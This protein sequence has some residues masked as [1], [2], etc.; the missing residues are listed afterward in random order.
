MNKNVF[1]TS[2]PRI[3]WALV[4]LAGLLMP[5]AS[6]AQAPS[7][8]F[9][10]VY[11]AWSPTPEGR[12]IDS[13]LYLNLDGS[14]LLVDDLLLGE[15]PTTRTGR[16]APG[17]TGVILTLTND[18]AGP[19]PQAI[20]VNLD[21]S[22]GQPLVTLPGDTAL[23]GRGWRF[24]AFP[25]L[26]EKRNALSYNADVATAAIAANG[27]G[28]VYKAIVPGSANDWSEVTLTLF[29]DFRVILKRNALDGR[30]P[31]LT[32]GAWQNIGGQ[33]SLTLTEADG[34]AFPTPVE[35]T[36]TVE[37]GLLRGQTTA[38]GSVADLVGIPFYRLEGLA[39]SV[40]VL[41]PGEVSAPGVTAPGNE[42]G[43]IGETALPAAPA[44]AP[45]PVEISI[46]Y[47][48]VFEAA[49]C[50]QEVQVDATITCGYLTAPE[51]R[52]RA[53]SASIRL[54]VVTL[55]AQ[56]EPAADPLFV[57]AGRA[58]E[59]S[60][61]LVQWFTNA[62]VRAKRNV[63]ILHP[64]GVGLSE[65]SL[66]CSEFVAS[67]ERQVMMQSLADCYNRLLQEGRDLAGYSLDQSAIDVAD[68][69]EALALEQ[70][71]LVGNGIGATVAQLVADRYPALV[72]SIVLES[73]LPVGVNEALESPFGA[74][75]ALRKV[76]ADCSRDAAC[77]AAYPDLESRFLEMIDWYN[78]N[79]TPASIGFGDGDAIARLV[80]TKLQM[81]G[82]DVPALINALYTGDFG[83]A[84]Q[85][86]PV[87]GGC[88]LPATGV[89]AP[90]NAITATTTITDS[91]PALTA[92]V[93]M[94]E[95]GTVDAVTPSP[96]APQSW[97]DYFT[98]PDNPEGAEEVTLAR[99]QTEL[100][101]ETRAELLQFLDSLAVENFLPLLAVTGAPAQSIAS[102]EGT[103][104]S[105]ACAEDAPR[106][107]IDD[108]QR[109]SKRLPSQVAAWLT[110][111][112][113]DLLETCS[114]WSTPPAAP[115]ARVLP[116]ASAPALVMA[117]AHDPV[118]PARWAR[119]AAADFEQV[120]VRIFAG[121]GHNLLQN[122]DSCAHA[123]LAAFVARPDQAPNLF[124]L[125]HQTPA[126]V[127][128]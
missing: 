56:S 4:L 124:C 20:V 10:G 59:D 73:P 123:V 75:D 110:A 48:P 100:G 116:I 54:F 65:P 86:A 64:R 58:G 8:V 114:L 95:A 28:G 47:E 112:A 15:A 39:N 122:P 103:R 17:G 121:A 26:V 117:G 62:P 67:E 77:G 57:L 107:T 120:F 79:P 51:N 27:L 3:G 2:L 118:T 1:R 60:S 29:P 108:V 61:A 6:L 33:P 70:I 83:V 125:R 16:W 42:P 23:D 98:N 36:F 85:L 93:E 52:N 9:A 19:L 32:Y 35:L 72:R 89:S 106:Y 115:G 7:S 40:A 22:A 128:P 78:Q 119:R 43:Q 71:N 94:G 34:L 127:L 76:F 18:A 109:I 99:I 82:S 92:T 46:Q 74:Y 84:C 38:A 53:D 21:A 44:T 25:Y 66:T 50:P 41:L 87:V 97:R 63:I 24:Y 5:T 30:A 13:T 55:A 91:A 68:L 49:P 31:S 45:T 105:I 81:G 101:L 11:K 12:V 80:F 102:I 126:F 37:G 90:A 88:L 69:A 111:P 96:A 104:L 14:A 113:A